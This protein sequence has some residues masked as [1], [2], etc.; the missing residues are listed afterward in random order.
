M[1]CEHC[2]C[3]RVDVEGKP[4]ARCC[5]CGHRKLVPPPATFGGGMLMPQ[6]FTRDRD[7]YEVYR[8]GGR[9]GYV[10]DPRD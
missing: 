1:T 8:L 5:N 7:A 10:E 2:Y 9:L 3:Q 4:H 6:G